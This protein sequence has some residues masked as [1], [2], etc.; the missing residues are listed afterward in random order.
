MK[1]VQIVTAILLLWASVALAEI[2]YTGTFTQDDQT[3]FLLHH[4]P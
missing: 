4:R 2:S 3:I 1:Q